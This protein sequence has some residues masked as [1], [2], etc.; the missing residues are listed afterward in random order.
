MKLQINPYLFLLSISLFFVQC[1]R[2]QLENLSGEV[3]E[4]T[5]MF[6]KDNGAN[7]AQ[8][9]NQDRITDNVWITRGN[10]G[11]QIFNAVLESEFD[12]RDSPLGTEWARGTTANLDALSFAPFR[13]TIMPQDVEG[14][15]LVMH[16]IEDDIFINV[17]FTSWSSNLGGGFAY[18]RTQL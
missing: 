1:S 2:D 8:E 18:T 3:I 9:A 4:E 15:D 14:V 17:R 10:E 12:K 7:P 11:G 5:I 16:L 13:A 6:T